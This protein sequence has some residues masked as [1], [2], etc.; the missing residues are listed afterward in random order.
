MGIFE[1]ETSLCCRLCQHQ[2]FLMDGWDWILDLILL[3]YSMKLW[4]PPK[5]LSGTDRWE[6]LSLISLQKE[7]WY[8]RI[9]CFILFYYLILL[10]ACSSVLG[11][12]EYVHVLYLSSLNMSCDA[13]DVSYVKMA[14]KSSSLPKHTPNSDL[15]Q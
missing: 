11:F 4:R 12:H 2:P 15:S 9:V 1:K 7:Q 8:A 14:T 6:C 13:V 3:R 10:L 5:Q